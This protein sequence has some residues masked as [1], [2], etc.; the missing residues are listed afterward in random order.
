[1]NTT[2]KVYAMQEC[3]NGPEIE[4]ATSLKEA[5]SI[6]AAWRHGLC[7]IC[8]GKVVISKEVE[9][10]NGHLD[11]DDICEKPVHRKSKKRDGMWRLSQC[12]NYSHRQAF[13]AC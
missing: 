2:Y 5:K 4:S 1:M 9:D 3:S 6:A 7:P 12:S 11:I 8:W 13:C 10:D